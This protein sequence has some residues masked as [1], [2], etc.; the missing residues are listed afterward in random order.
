MKLVALLSLALVAMSVARAADDSWI[1]VQALNCEFTIPGDYVVQAQSEGTEF[2]RRSRAGYGRISLRS[3][4]DGEAEPAAKQ[5]EAEASGHLKIIRYAV[6]SG[7][8]RI[9]DFSYTVVRGLSDQLVFASEAAKL[10][11]HVVQGCIATV[12]APFLEAAKRRD[13]GCKLVARER[14]ESFFSQIRPQPVFANGRNVGWRVYERHNQN[15]L[16]SLG[17]RQQDLV[18]HFCGAS[19][20]EIT[21]V[22]GSICCDDMVKDS[23]KLKVIRDGRTM[24]MTVPVTPNNLLKAD[25]AGAPRP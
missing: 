24:D 8:E 5:L 23:V 2:Y 22:S 1:Q 9:P 20:A 17:L 6:P 18:T 4:T 19:I 25:G 11:P 15:A 16:P 12:A 7:D 13:E 3:L 21:G 10:V 14:F